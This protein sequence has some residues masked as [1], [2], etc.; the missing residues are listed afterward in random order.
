MG[1]QL[2]TTR[3]L[4]CVTKAPVLPHEGEANEVAAELL[5]RIDQQQNF[6]MIRCNIIWHLFVSKS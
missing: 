4:H 1:R 3:S 5:Q 6:W 2:P